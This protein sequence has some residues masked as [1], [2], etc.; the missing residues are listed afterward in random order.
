MIQPG[1]K[2]ETIC[3]YE[4]YD[5]DTE[6]SDVFKNI[7]IDSGEVKKEKAIIAKKKTAK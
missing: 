3:R 2:Y 7:E 6:R 1:G 5:G 4:V